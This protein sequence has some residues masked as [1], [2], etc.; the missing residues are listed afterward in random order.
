VPP[1]AIPAEVKEKLDRLAEVFPTQVNA[2]GMD[3]V[4][5]PPA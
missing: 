2:E 5:A 4:D 1:A 3:Q